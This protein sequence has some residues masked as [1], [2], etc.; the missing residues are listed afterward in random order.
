MSYNTDHLRTAGKSLCIPHSLVSLFL[1]SYLFSILRKP[2]Q[3]SS[4]TEHCYHHRYRT[5]HSSCMDRLH[6]RGDRISI[7]NPTNAG[8]VVS[9][10]AIG[11]DSNAE[12][13]WL[14]ICDTNVAPSTTWHAP[15][16]S[17][18]NGRFQVLPQADR[19][20]G[21]KA[22]QPPIYTHV[23]QKNSVRLSIM[24]SKNHD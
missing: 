13:Y 2:N 5:Q 18:S 6:Y 14:L 17:S 16:C 12:N 9:W 15:H 19:R 1:Q 21:Q 20:L 8:D 24:I 3:T 4:S 11:T 22:L 10:T 23:D 7:A